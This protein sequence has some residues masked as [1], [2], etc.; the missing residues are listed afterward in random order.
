[1]YSLHSR[2][3]INQFRQARLNKR[4][5]EQQDVGHL[6]QR[7]RCYMLAFTRYCYTRY[8]MVYGIQTGGRGGGSR[9]LRDS[10][11]IVLQ[12]FEQCRWAEEMKGGLIRI[13]TT[14]SKRISCKGQAIWV[15]NGS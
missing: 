1:V 13:Q 10:R 3:S 6:E 8:C 2:G 4:V 14:Q 9:I 12:Q 5:F 7:G 15:S 11:A